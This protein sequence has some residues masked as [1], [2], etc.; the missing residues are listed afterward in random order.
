MSDFHF[1]E[2]LWLLLLG[3]PLLL[4]WLPHRVYSLHREERLRHYADSHL[5]PHLLVQGHLGTG[6]ERSLTHWNWVWALG[7][8]A[9][10]GPR[11]D[12]HDIDLYQPGSDLVVLLDLSRSMEVA[13]VKP[14][15]SARARQEI[16][17]LLRLKSGLRVGLVGFASVA[18]VIA[19]ITDDIQ[20]LHNL[21][22]SL[23]PELVRLPGSRLSSALE[24][25]KRLLGGQP[26]GGQQT[27][28]VISDGDFDEPDLEG[29]VRQLQANGIRLF[30]L[31]VG[32]SQ[33]GEVP[34]PQG[35]GFIKDYAGNPIHSSLNELQLRDLAGA[36]GGSYIR[37]EYHDDDTRALLKQLQGPGRALE[38]GQQ[39][40]W[41]ERYYLLVGIMMWLLLS[42]FLPSR[43]IKS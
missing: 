37:A 22:P 23:S 35:A 8:L 6:S 27:L 18:H 24:R 39:R 31:G 32:T 21:L 17:D 4:R 7:V 20:T 12:Y 41:H 5:L 19:P 26:P 38:S 11:W 29:Q 15:R 1:S 14:T 40:V 42:W 9:M 10:A 34:L 28:L 33:G 3:L 2:P 13:D 43:I 36:G 16:D 25:A 30:T